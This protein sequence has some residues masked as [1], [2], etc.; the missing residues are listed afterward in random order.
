MMTR[1]L[2]ITLL[3]GGLFFAIKYLF[4]YITE[5]T[6]MNKYLAL[7]LALIIGLVLCS[8]IINVLY[9]IGLFQAT[10]SSDRTTIAPVSVIA[11]LHDREGLTENDFDLNMLKNS[12]KL[13]IDSCI[14]QIRQSLA[15]R[16]VT[17]TQLSP[18][19]V[20]E[21]HFVTIAGKKLG[22]I[23]LNVYPSKNDQTIISKAIRIIG[24]TPQGIETVNCIVSGDAN[25]PLYF[26]ECGEKVQQ[27]FGV[28]LHK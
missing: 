21:S 5:N 28:S 18:I 2:S 16:G 24:F 15:S 9:S 8:G 20:S 27:V 12:E 25:I 7:L 13:A 26:G 22:I 10:N 3:L 17:S 23:T 1:L 11:T 4:K 14:Q 6:K 19:P